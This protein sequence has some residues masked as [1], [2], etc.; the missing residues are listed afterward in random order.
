M[1]LI[2]PISVNIFCRNNVIIQLTEVPVVD[3]QVTKQ[4]C[5]SFN[6]AIM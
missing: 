6:D 3:Q 1:I 5:L 2:S 4:N